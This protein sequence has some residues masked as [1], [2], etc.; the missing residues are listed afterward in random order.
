MA[1]DAR[2]Y[3]IATPKMADTRHKRLFYAY[4]RDEGKSEHVAFRRCYLD[5]DQEKNELLL[6]A[7][8]ELSSTDDQWMVL[9]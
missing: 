1:A 6:R 4:V 8:P 9:V 7:N 5:N 2:R 3:K